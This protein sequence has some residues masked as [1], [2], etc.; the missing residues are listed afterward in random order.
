MIGRPS[1]PYLVDEQE[2][3][4][5]TSIQVRWVQR[6]WQLVKERVFPKAE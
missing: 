6:V 3:V 4:A 2:K 5:I 1:E